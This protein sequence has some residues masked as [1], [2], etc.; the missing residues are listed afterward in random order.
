MAIFRVAGSANGVVPVGFTGV[1]LG[2]LGGAV[3]AHA[4]LGAARMVG[5]G[6]VASWGDGVTLIRGGAGADFLYAGLGAVRLEGGTGNDFLKDGGGAARGSL[7]FGGEGDDRIVMAAT[8]SK[9]IGGGGND[10]F[11]IKSV[12][13]AVASGEAGDDTFIVAGTR[14]ASLHGGAGADRFLLKNASGV[15]ANGGD[16]DDLLQVTGGEGLRGTLGAGN[17]KVVLTYALDARVNTGEGND[18]VLIR[19]G[20]GVVVTAGD[21][22]DRVHVGEGTYLH[23]LNGGDGIDTLIFW[24][25][26]AQHRLPV[27]IDLAAGTMVAEHTLMARAYQF[28]NAVG[29]DGDDQIFGNDGVNQLF[30]GAGDDFIDGRGGGDFLFG[31]AGHD[32]LFGSA[33]DDV[34]DG[35]IGNDYLAGSFGADRFVFS[36]VRA[37]EH[38]RMQSFGPLDRLDFR[39]AADSLDDL[40][41]TMHADG[42]ARIKVAAAG[43]WHIIDIDFVSDP[44]SLTTQLASHV[45]LG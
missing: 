45:L 4:A 11:A 25:Q 37:G 42:S 28:E 15:T 21:G 31:G 36:S 1:D 30:G 27:T 43:G 5:G 22:N 8:G 34:L 44:A 38:D 26:N 41:V 24:E 29:G 14:S 17:D 35:G 19:R 16:G 7:L 6:K 10:T 9:G 40:Q 3:V 20:D 18:Q 2:N 33:G 32:T 39:G 13:G 23:H 12:V